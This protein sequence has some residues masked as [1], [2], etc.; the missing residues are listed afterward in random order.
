M[1]FVPALEVRVTLPPTQNANGP[2]ALIVGVTGRA[3][4]VTTT[5][6][7]TVVNPSLTATL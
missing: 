5:G 3:L 4:T 7:L 2:D 6:E 1:Y